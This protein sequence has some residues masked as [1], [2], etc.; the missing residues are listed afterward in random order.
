MI[1]QVLGY[2]LEEIVKIVKIRSIAALNFWTV[3]SL[4]IYT[5]AF[6]ALGYRIADL[7]EKHDK[8]AMRYRLKAFQ[9]LSYAGRW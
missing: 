6:I 2:T 5:L 4:S 9:I 1:D 3:V 8:H 7:A